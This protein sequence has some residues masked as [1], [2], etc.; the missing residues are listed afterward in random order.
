MVPGVIQDESHYFLPWLRRVICGTDNA[1]IGRSEWPM[2][3]EGKML[4]V[5]ADGQL[6]LKRNCCSLFLADNTRQCLFGSMLTAAAFLGH[7]RSLVKLW[8]ASESATCFRRLLS[9]MQS[10]LMRGRSHLGSNQQRGQCCFL[11]FF[12]I[13]LF[14]VEDVCETMQIFASVWLKPLNQSVRSR[15]VTIYKACVLFLKIGTCLSAGAQ[16]SCFLRNCPK[17]IQKSCRCLFPSLGVDCDNCTQASSRRPP[18]PF[19]ASVLWVTWLLMIYHVLPF[20]PVDPCCFQTILPQISYFRTGLS[21]IWD[22][23]I[24]HNLHVDWW[25]QVHITGRLFLS[26][27]VRRM[28]DAQNGDVRRSRIESSSSHPFFFSI[29]GWNQT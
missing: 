28:V 27:D 29:W 21:R 7:A 8:S 12:C 4:G 6:Q 9:R 19:A 20:Y 5:L 2:F 16:M 17:S 11:C 1:H 22:R 23:Y 25:T 3:C 15:C 13:L 10:Q 26:G 24:S 14:H 18:V